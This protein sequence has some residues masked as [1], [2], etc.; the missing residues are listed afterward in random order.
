MTRAK[1]APRPE[2]P[3]PV[4]ERVSAALRVLAHPHRLK[5][6]EL[7]MKGERPVGELA[8]R[9]GLAPNAVSQHLNI[10]KAYGI[11]TSRR[12]G[13][14]ILYH[15]QNPEARNVIQCIRRYYCGA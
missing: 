11:L 8:E 6:V 12:R 14:S 4:L 10:M 15:V 7:L 3:L 9:M 13:R 1:K 5:L 2:I